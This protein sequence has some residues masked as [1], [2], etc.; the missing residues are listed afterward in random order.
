MPYSI[1]YE[2]RS[3]IDIPFCLCN[4]LEVQKEDL[5]IPTLKRFSIASYIFKTG[6]GPIY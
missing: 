1:V 4:T 2:N 3:T 6:L 5:H